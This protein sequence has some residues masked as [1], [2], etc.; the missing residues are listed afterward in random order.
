[1]FAAAGDVD[2][3]AG[4]R[5]F[6]RTEG[7]DPEPAFRRPSRRHP[8]AR[9]EQRVAPDF[10]VTLD[11]VS[12]LGCDPS[13]ERTSDRAL[14]AGLA[15]VDA[16]RVR[17]RFPP[18]TYRFDIAHRFEGYDAL[19]FVAAES[20]SGGTDG[21]DRTDEKGTTRLVA[22][23]N[24]RREWFRTE[25]VGAFVFR[26]IDLDIRAPG[27]GPSVV[28]HVERALLIEDVRVRG[29]GEGDANLLMPRVTSPNGVGVFRRFEARAGG[30]LGRRRIGV[31]IGPANRGTLRFEACRLEEFPN[32]GLY[33]SASRGAIRVLGGTY[34]NND[35]SQLRLSGSDCVVRGTLVAVDT[36]AYDGPSRSGD[37]PGYRNPRGIWWEAKRHSATG[38]RVEYTTIRIHRG[39]SVGG[40]VIAKNGGAIT[41]FR[42]AIEVDA[43]DAPGIHAYEPT[44][45]Y[46][47]VPPRPW[48][49]RLERVHVY[50]DSDA[51]AIDIRGRPAS[52]VRQSCIANGFVVA[53]R[54]ATDL[55]S[56]VRILARDG[57][58]LV[59]ARTGCFDE[60]VGA[61]AV[62]SASM[63]PPAPLGDGDADVT[64]P[65]G[66]IAVHTA[67]LV[68]VLGVA[69]LL[70]VGLLVA[71]GSTLRSLF[72]ALR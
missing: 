63:P 59:G 38:G 46:Y 60:R 58:R 18:G 32:N 1:M 34:R 35:I 47:R 24:F 12:D 11:A 15:G 72:D 67:V 70:S 56:R 50:G 27:C 68:G 37:S 43:T 71:A 69:C 51:P 55:L 4:E 31:W 33:A 45:G 49:V 62:P 26:G 2:I 21:T 64:A 10:D 42:T 17:V 5:R 39:S 14:N 65:L 29:R 8:S 57:R 13:G 36:R 53:D 61:G 16:D 54:P 9:F 7:P 40:V 22:P 41:I 28:P 20:E 44:G 3:A 48:R 52:S 66:P 6:T 19:G 30:V 23:P 25:N